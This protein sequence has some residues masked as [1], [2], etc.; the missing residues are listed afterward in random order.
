MTGWCLCDPFFGCS[1]CDDTEPY[2]CTTTLCTVYVDYKIIQSDGTEVTLQDPKILYL[3]MD[4]TAYLW[5]VIFKKGTDNR[6]TGPV[7]LQYKNELNQWVTFSTFSTNV[8]GSVVITFTPMDFPTIPSKAVSLRTV[9]YLSGVAFEQ[10]TYT[11]MLNIAKLNSSI[12]KTSPNQLPAGYNNVTGRLVDENGVPIPYRY[13]SLIV[14]N[15]TLPPIQTSATGTWS[16]S[17]PM[18]ADA[19]QR[20]I[21][22]EFVGDSLYNPSTLTFALFVPCVEGSYRYPVECPDGSTA[23]QSICSNGRYITNP[24][25]CGCTPGQTA[26]PVVCS[27]GTTRYYYQCGQDSKWAYNAEPC[28]KVCNNGEYHQVECDNGMIITTEICQNNA[29]MTTGDACPTHICD[30]GA[31][32]VPIVCP[33]GTT[34]YYLVCANNQWVPT[35][36]TCPPLVCLEGETKVGVC[37]DGS[38]IITQQCYNNVWVDTDN[39]CPPVI[40]TDGAKKNPIFC[41][42]GSKIYQQV[43]NN[44]AWVAS[45]ETCPDTAKPFDIKKYVPVIAIA[46][47]GLV[48]AILL[49]K[50]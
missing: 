17:I 44:N 2:I 41:D 22:L 40:C 37:D 50:R 42:D 32:K 34:K 47:V 29:W 7:D 28:P 39:E 13:I 35:N 23:Y 24:A 49:M 36:A 25:Q 20:E 33:D 38:S 15:Q 9:A 18:V 31:T 3:H 43:C 19:P 48:G 10:E 45:G 6:Y 21:I 14:D 12:I 16:F 5:Q 1:D 26:L 30:E 4:D 11:V 8:N 46:G 27:D